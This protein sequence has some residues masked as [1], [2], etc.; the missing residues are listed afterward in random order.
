LQSNLGSR[1]EKTLSAFTENS[2]RYRLTWR[3]DSRRLSCSHQASTPVGDGRACAGATVEEMLLLNISKSKSCLATYKELFDDSVLRTSAYKD[4]LEVLT[5]FLARQPG[6]GS[7]GLETGEKLYD[8]LAA[9][10]KA[11]L[12]R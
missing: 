12:I 7:G 1:F 10:S 5:D 2:H 9:P 6:F 4:V 3:D 8:I 11:F